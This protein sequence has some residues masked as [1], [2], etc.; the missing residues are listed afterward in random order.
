[1]INGVVPVPL[2]AIDF[3]LKI[4]DAL[5]EFGHRQRIEILPGKQRQRIIGA[6][7]E[8]LVGIHVEKR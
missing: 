3:S 6:T 8:I 5:V 1:M 7:R 4:G 2:H